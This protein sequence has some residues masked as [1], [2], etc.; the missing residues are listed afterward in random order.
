MHAWPT[1]PGSAAHHCVLRSIRDDIGFIGLLV[2]MPDPGDRILLARIGAPHGVKGAV[3]IRTFT[4]DP[5]TIG[6]YGPLF[7]KDGRSFT[8]AEIRPDKAGVVARLEGVADRNAAEALK[9]VELYV[10]RSVLPPPEEDEF[11]Y[12]DLIGLAAERSDGSPLGTVKSV[13]DYGAGEFLELEPPDGKTMLI[14]FTKAAVPVIDIQAG[15]IVIEPPPEIE[16]SE[17]EARRAEREDDTP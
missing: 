11:Y 10:D 1:D 17:E 16:V 12:S 8:L 3:R 4:D 7:A 14:P 15:R 9:G 5:V 13:Q 6:D 2:S